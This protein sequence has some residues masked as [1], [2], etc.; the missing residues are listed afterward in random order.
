M[1]LLEERKSYSLRNFGSSG[2]TDFVQRDPI[3]PGIEKDQSLEKRWSRGLSFANAAR[4][5]ICA[6]LLSR[7]I[8]CSPALALNF[9]DWSWFD[10][11]CFAI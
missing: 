9:L 11:L 5:S 10:E 4:P 6:A 3:Q 8:C 2:Q 7:Q 1:P